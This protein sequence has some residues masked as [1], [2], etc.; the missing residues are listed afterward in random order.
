MRLA[1]EINSKELRRLSTLL[2]NPEIVL[3]YSNSQLHFFSESGLFWKSLSFNVKCEEEFYIRI[4]SSLFRYLLAR[5]G[6]LVFSIEDNKIILAFASNNK[7][8]TAGEFDAVSEGEYQKVNKSILQDYLHMIKMAKTPE[9]RF[10]S[11]ENLKTLISACAAAESGLQV[12]NGYAIV[13]GDNM[14]IY[15]PLE[16]NNLKAGFT[17]TA[18]KEIEKFKT[19]CDAVQIKNYIIL[20]RD[21]YILGV[22]KAVVNEDIEQYVPTSFR[23]NAQALGVFKVNFKSVGFLL[24]GL[25]IELFKKTQTPPKLSL[26]FKNSVAVFSTE[27]N[28][29]KL[30]MTTNSFKLNIESCPQV[31]SVSVLYLSKLQRLINSKDQVDAELSIAVYPDNLR[32]D[33]ADGSSALLRGEVC[34]GS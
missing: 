27:R 2:K 23:Q 8:F 22:V 10:D 7:K 34:V 18:L 29:V 12:N 13:V 14:R 15:Y 30:S 17:V 20:R 28:S 6:I 21:E 26:D 16:S 9:L 32:L 24:A 33:F 5:E 11:L 19:N 31:V 25:D 3:M 1:I 4:E